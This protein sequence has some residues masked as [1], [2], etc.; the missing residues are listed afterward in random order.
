MGEE[1]VQQS[2]TRALAAFLRGSEVCRTRQ[3]QPLYEI[4]TRQKCWL[5]GAFSRS[6]VF[7]LFNKN[8]VQAQLPKQLTWPW[9][10]ARRGT[11]GF[12]ISDRAAKRDVQHSRS[13][14]PLKLRPNPV[15]QSQNKVV[16]VT[17]VRTIHLPIKLIQSNP[18]YPTERAEQIQVR[19]REQSQNSP[20]CHTKAE[21]RACMCINI[22]E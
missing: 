4:K 8:A 1:R 9:L 10:G 21:Q 13:I 15:T 17:A 6:A 5:A 12:G 3:V 16:S 7:P 20:L 19:E 2:R 11:R 14:C 22:Y 18:L